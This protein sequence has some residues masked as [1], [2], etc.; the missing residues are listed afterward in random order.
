[1]DPVSIIGL[2]ETTANV[3]KTLIELADKF[4]KAPSSLARVTSE[5]E[6]L[7]EQ[8]DRFYVIQRPLARE[9]REYLDRQ[10]GS[11]ECRALVMELRKK[12]TE[13]ISNGASKMTFLDR[14]KWLYSGGE[15]EELVD[16]LGKETDR[17]WKL[18]LTHVVLTRET[19]GC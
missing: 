12:A 19:G 6:K 8:L 18:L 1:M 3:V 2:L 7:R 9:Q 13:A 11:L 16:R 10:V 15:V 4:K 14:V 17:L 5:T